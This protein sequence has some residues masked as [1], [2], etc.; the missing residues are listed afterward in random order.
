MI[1]SGTV[2][3]TL[4]LLAIIAIAT[5]RIVYIGSRPKALDSIRRCWS[6]RCFM[7][8]GCNR[9]VVRLIKG[10]AYHYI[11]GAPKHH[12]GHCT[13]CGLKYRVLVCRGCGFIPTKP[14]EICEII[15]PR[16]CP[17]CGQKLTSTYTIP[18]DLVSASSAP[19]E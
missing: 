1:T 11:I 2:L 14:R 9:L 8:C 17:K 13:K 3:V 7:T 4:L 6:E 19:A 10:G 16:F 5:N 15:P 18:A 12:T